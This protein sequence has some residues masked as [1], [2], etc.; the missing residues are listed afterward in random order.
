MLAMPFASISAPAVVPQV[1]VSGLAQPAE[2]VPA[3]DGSK[4]C[5]PELAGSR[6]RGGDGK[7]D[8]LRTNAATGATTLWL[9]DGASRISA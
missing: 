1:M 5:R 3:G 7:A 2:I 8:L 6:V 4:A 9:M